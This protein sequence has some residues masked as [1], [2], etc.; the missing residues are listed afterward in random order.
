MH[1]E[2][3]GNNLA[4]VNLVLIW[5][6]RCWVALP[7]SN[8]RPS[9]V[10]ADHA[11]DRQRRRPPLWPPSLAFKKVKLYSR[12]KMP[13]DRTRRTTTS[14]DA[15]E[16]AFKAVTTKPAELPPKRPTI[17]NAKELVSLRID[18]DILDHFQEAGPGWQDR[19][20]EALRKVVGR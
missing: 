13:D 15:A 6:C 2:G 4:A 8:R 18:R 3:T 19:I 12:N 10:R 5:F 20:N 9:C 7:P 16:A 17:P 14:R 1:P 11:V